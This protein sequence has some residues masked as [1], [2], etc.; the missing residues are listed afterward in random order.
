M[1]KAPT[2]GALCEVLRG[3]RYQLWAEELLQMELLS[4]RWVSAVRLK[5]RPWTASRGASEKYTARHVSL[6][7]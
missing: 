1:P 5:E 3:T 6:T 2:S 7:G 4:Y